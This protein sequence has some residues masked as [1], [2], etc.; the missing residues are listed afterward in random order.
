[1]AVAEAQRAGQLSTGH[2]VVNVG[3][4]HQLPGWVDAEI[5]ER[6]EVDLAKKGTQFPPEQLAGFADTL[7]DCL[8]PNGT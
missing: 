4:C 1:M 8:N 2:V 7:A 3:F 6:A 5:R